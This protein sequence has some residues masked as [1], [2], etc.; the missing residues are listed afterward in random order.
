MKGAGLFSKLFTSLPFRY[1][2]L[3]T[4]PLLPEHFPKSR[5]SILVIGVSLSL[6]LPPFLGFLDVVTDVVWPPPPPQ[7]ISLAETFEKTSERIF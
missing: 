2:R 5:Q 1:I 7:I 6:F 3:H 4:G